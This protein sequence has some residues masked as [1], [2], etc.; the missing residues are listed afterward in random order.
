MDLS[1]CLD[2]E[3]FVNYMLVYNICG[4]R[5]I[6]W[7]KSLYMYKRSIDDVYHFGPVWDFDWAFS[8]DNGTEDKSPDCRVGRCMGSIERPAVFQKNM[9][10]F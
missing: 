3:S 9:F 10:Y 2:M 4:N 5:E 7:P 8:Y 1:D 6:L